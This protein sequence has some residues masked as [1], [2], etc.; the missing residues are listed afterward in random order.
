MNRK[1]L[2]Q[3]IK[4]ILISFSLYFVLLFVCIRVYNYFT[5][6]RQNNF[7]TVTADIKT[8][9]GLKENALVRLSGIDIGKVESL[10]LL[11]DFSVKVFM[12]IDNVIQIPD[13]SS[14]A[15]YTD[16]LLGEKYISILPGGSMDYMS[17]GSEFEFAQDSVDVSEM[18]K[19]GIEQWN[20]KQEEK[21]AK[22]CSSSE[23]K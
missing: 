22:K 20:K 6:L 15:I 19:L 8:T 18:I 21:E 7:Y 13:D 23:K 11:H 2:K 1:K 4:K 12:K 10:K 16:G 9:D 3:K 5:S 14:V 17:N